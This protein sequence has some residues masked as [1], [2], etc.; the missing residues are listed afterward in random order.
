MALHLYNG[1][2]KPV[3]GWSRLNEGS[4]SSVVTIDTVSHSVQVCVFCYSC[5]PHRVV[6]L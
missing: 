4:C 5:A 2:L 6:V 3:L 1:P